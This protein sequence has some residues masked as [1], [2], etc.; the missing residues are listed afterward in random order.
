M[1]LTFEFMLAL[2]SDNLKETSLSIAKHK[3]R[4]SQTR[5]VRLKFAS[6][7]EDNLSREEESI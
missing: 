3:I 6:K 5:P 4:K 2:A 7:E 1:N